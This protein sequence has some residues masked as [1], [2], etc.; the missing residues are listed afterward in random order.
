MFARDGELRNFERV[1]AFELGNAFRPASFAAWVSPL[2]RR[3]L[4]RPIHNEVPA[5]VPTHH[6]WFVSHL[7]PANEQGRAG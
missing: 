6:G 1:T 4:A 3:M 5:N 2:R 7:G